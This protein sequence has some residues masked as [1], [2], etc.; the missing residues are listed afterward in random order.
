MPTNVP[1]VFKNVSQGPDNGYVDITPLSSIEDK[2]I[3]WLWKN[4][5]P[6][7]MLALLAGKPGIGKSTLAYHCAAV[8]SRG[9]VWPDGSKAKKGYVFIWSS[10]D[11]YD[12]VI[13][14]RIKKMGG[15]LDYVCILNNTLANGQRKKFDPAKDIGVLMQTIVKFSR[16]SSDA[17]SLLIIDPITSAITGDSHKTAEV[18]TGLQQ[19]VD[20]GNLFN[21]SI[22]GLTHY[23]KD[24]AGR[25]PVERVIGSI[26]FAAFSRIVL[27]AAKHEDSGECVICR[28]KSNIGPDK[29]GYKYSILIEETN[30]AGMDVDVTSVEWGEPLDGSA[31]KILAIVEGDGEQPRAHSDINNALSF[32]MEML[33]DGPQKSEYLIELARNQLGIEKRTLQRA[34]QRMNLKP[35]PVKDESGKVSHWEVELPGWQFS[36]KLKA[37]TNN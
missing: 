18:R 9:G 32:L 6:K 35:R 36:Q 2:P 31:R 24:S 12:K 3:E 13:K 20:L 29:G 11:P 5:L 23:S 26:G 21:C 14:Q 37:L 19:L 33:K 1:S 15:D 17:P 7:G 28:A 4:W 30:V 22:L 8:I 25:D 34:Y 10:E 16:D 27:V